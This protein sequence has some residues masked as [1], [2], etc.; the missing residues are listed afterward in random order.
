MT[1]SYQIDNQHQRV[2]LVAK[3]PIDFESMH[4]QMNKLMRDD[5]YHPNYSILADFSDARYVPSFREIR[6]F[7]KLFREV[8]NSF[9]GKVAFLVHDQTQLNAG[10]FAS[11]IAR[12]LDFEMNV[13]SERSDALGWMENRQEN[14]ME[15]L[16]H[17]ILDIITPFQLSVLGTVLPDGSP[18]VRYV[19]TRG[20]SNM[21]IFIATPLH[22]RKVEQIKTNSKVHLTCGC[23]DI[24]S[25]KAWVQ[26][27]GNAV[28]KTDTATRQTVWNEFL[29][30]Y[31]S[32]ADDEEYAVIVVTPSQIEYFTM[33]SLI[34]EVLKL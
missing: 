20:D 21:K 33:A 8:S 23:A 4:S 29:R 15:S 16:R 25:A 32:G 10:R 12:S 11:A 26:I 28:V 6:Q 17:K 27:A 30:A 7:G 3:G 14:T 19:T 22:S 34:P 2:D 5:S 1:V 24:S 13:F 31:F 18:W 9:R